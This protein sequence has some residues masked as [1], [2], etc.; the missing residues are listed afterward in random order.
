MKYNF[1]NIKLIDIEGN[2][3]KD[4]SLPKVIGNAIYSN[5]KDLGMVDIARDIYKGEEVELDEKQIEEVKTIVSASFAAFA[6]IAILDYVDQI[7]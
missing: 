3:V 6:Q 1:S 7:K 5:T 2:E 4:N